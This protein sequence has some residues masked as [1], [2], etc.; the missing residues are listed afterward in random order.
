MDD[1]L[2]L[3]PEQDILEQLNSYS[4]STKMYWVIDPWVEIHPDFDFSTYPTQ[5]DQDCVH[6]FK[7][8]HDTISQCQAGA[9]GLC[10]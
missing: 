1:V 5:W 9:Q 4:S 8:N 10:V 2:R 7:D 3:D 6:V